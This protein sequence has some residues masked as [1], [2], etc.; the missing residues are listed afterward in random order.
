M[1]CPN[2][3]LIPS[4]DLAR[5][6][7]Q[8]QPGLLGRA[9]LG[10]SAPR[11]PWPMPREHMVQACPVAWPAAAGRAGPGGPCSTRGLAWYLLRA[12][13][14]IREVSTQAF[15]VLLRLS[16]SPCPFITKQGQ[17]PPLPPSFSAGTVSPGLYAHSTFQQVRIGVLL[18]LRKPRGGATPPGRVT[19]C[20]GLP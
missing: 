2:S 7:T 3:P 13:F 18:Q 17:S 5:C 11:G 12:D 8:A 1:N 10:Q 4:Q 19:N 20:H 15:C 9:P 14:G 6:R 16:G